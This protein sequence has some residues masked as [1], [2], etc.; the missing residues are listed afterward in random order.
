MLLTITFALSHNLTGE[1][2]TDLLS[3]IACH[4]KTPNLCTLSVRMFKKH[5]ENLKR[6]LVCH[7]YCKFCF[8]LRVDVNTLQFRELLLHMDKEQVSKSFFIER[9]I[10]EQLKTLLSSKYIIF[11][12]SW[13]E[14]YPAEIAS[15]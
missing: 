10:A 7:Y 14:I 11:L 3:L 15:H 13:D 4:C 8:A 1:A 12:T 5:F 6:P 9:P 2:L